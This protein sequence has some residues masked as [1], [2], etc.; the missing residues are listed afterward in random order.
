MQDLEGAAV[1]SAND[2]AGYL[3][4]EHLITLER[5]AISHL[6]QTTA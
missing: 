6:V 2:P 4:C 3:E 5:A 1:H